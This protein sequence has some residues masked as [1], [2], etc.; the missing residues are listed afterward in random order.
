M[1]NKEIDCDVC[2]CA[3]GSVSAD[4]L[5][6]PLSPLELSIFTIN[7]DGFD[8]CGQML[9]AINKSRSTKVNNISQS[10]VFTT[11]QKYSQI[12]LLEMNQNNVIF[13]SSSSSKLLWI[14]S[15]LW[16]IE[17]NMQGHFMK[18]CTI[19]KK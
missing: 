8:F 4:L 14:Y 7:S 13:S 16:N 18:K 5:S 1:L 9:M 17:L 10:P 6:F 12:W 3:S 11:K 2:S 19:L 15:R